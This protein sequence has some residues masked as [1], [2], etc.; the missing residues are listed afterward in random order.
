MPLTAKYNNNRKMKFCNLTNIN[1][2]VK[3][4]TAFFDCTCGKLCGNCGKHSKIAILVKKKTDV[5][6]ENYLQLITILVF[7]MF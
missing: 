2:N 6:V 1:K 3:K 7:S 4:I 5:P